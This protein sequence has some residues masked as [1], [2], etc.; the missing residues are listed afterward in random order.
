M[1][2]ANSFL[3]PITNATRDKNFFVPQHN[4]K[5]KLIALSFIGAKWN[6]AFSFSGR[7]CNRAYLNFK[8]E[9]TINVSYQKKERKKEKQSQK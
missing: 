6:F 2:R 9:E 1:R 5:L 7:Q 3:F 8:K 4:V